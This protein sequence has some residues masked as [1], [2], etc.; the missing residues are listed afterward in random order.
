MEAHTSNPNDLIRYYRCRSTLIEHDLP[1]SN[2]M[3]F[4]RNLAELAEN[5][6]LPLDERLAAVALAR[7]VLASCQLIIDSNP[8][9]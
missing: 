4:F 7:K 9:T 6:E 5:S 8:R 3:E 1:R 2:P